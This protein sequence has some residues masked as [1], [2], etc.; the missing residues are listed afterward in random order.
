LRKFEG[1]TYTFQPEIDEKSSKLT[2]SKRKG[3]VENRLMDAGKK[4]DK[5]I[6]D[7]YK[8]LQGEMFKP[9]FN[10]N[11]KWILERKK[12]EELVKKKNGNSENIDY[13]EAIPKCS[14]ENHTMKNKTAALFGT[15]IHRNKS[16]SNNGG[17]SRSKRKRARSRSNNPVTE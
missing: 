7:L 3:R 16:Q 13:F 15:N 2:R 11:S 1:N 14:L 12:K 5:K 17:R 6:Q 8:K 10:L 9:D 4:K